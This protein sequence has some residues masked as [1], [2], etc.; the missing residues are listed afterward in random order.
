MKKIGLGVAGILSATIFIFFIGPRPNYIEFD[1]KP[2]NT[3]YEVNDLADLIDM[4]NQ[5]NRIRPGTESKIIWNDS[6]RKT[7]YSIVY[8]HGFSATHPEGYPIHQNIAKQFGCNLFLTRFPEHGLADINSYKYVDPKQ[9]I[10]YGKKA[11]AIGKSIGEKVII[12]STSTGG[13]IS[14]YLSAHDPAIAGQILFSPNIDLFDTNSNLLNGPWGFQLGKAVLGSEYRHIEG[15]DSV[16][17]YW[18]MDYHIQGLVALRELLD[19]TMTEEIFAKI[20]APVFLGYYYKDESHKDEVVSIPAMNS[21]LS[22][23][24]IDTFLIKKHIF[25]EAG[26]HVLASKYWNPNWKNVEKAVSS[27][28]RNT[29]NI[30]L[31]NQ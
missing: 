19:I 6:I 9:W 22:A 15:P 18:T 13:T 2:F 14:I 8:F 7:K 21:F 29:L 11:I 24:T 27:F 28:M 26:N 25:P 16:Q 23:L 5:D 31:V 1:G 3:F 30:P 20:T 12:M 17:K 10:D 4:E